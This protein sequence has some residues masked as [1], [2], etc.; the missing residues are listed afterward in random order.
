M[1]LALSMKT[2]NPMILFFSIC[3]ALVS[4]SLSFPTHS[5][6]TN[7]IPYQ[8]TWLKNHYNERMSMF[9]LQPLKEGDI[10]FI[11]DSITEM[12]MNWGV[13]FNDTRV[14]NRGIKA[15]MTYGVLAR[16]NEM[17]V[18]SPKAIFILIG[19]NDIFNL[20]YQQEIQQ[21]SSIAKNIQKITN[22][23]R[24]SLPDT[25]IFVQ[26]L[27]PDHRDFISVLAREVNQQIEQIPNKQFQYIELH[28]SFVTPDGVLRPELTTDGTHLNAE[29][30]ALWHKILQPYIEAL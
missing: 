2:T 9:Q 6:Q 15:D 5:A 11:G 8:S 3:A 28:S 12:G 13:R 16:L 10:V 30:Y 20:Y 14:K 25:Q 22:E 26:S 27:L 29:G 4:T 18:S 17:Q 1:T 19:I 7:E 24:T 23:L 21:L